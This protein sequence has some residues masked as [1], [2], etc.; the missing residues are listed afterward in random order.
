M[1]FGQE[2]R[3]LPNVKWRE[4][5]QG[6]EGRRMELMPS[7]FGGGLHVGGRSEFQAEETARAKAPEASVPVLFE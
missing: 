7:H 1:G 4:M 3:K 2:T 6:E 5:K